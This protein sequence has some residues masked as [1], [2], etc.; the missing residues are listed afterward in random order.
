M[1]WPSLRRGSDRIV[2]HHPERP[3]ALGQLRRLRRDPDHGCLVAAAGPVRVLPVLG[4]SLLQQVGIGFPDQRR[5]RPRPGSRNLLREHQGSAFDVGFYGIVQKDLR[6][7]LQRGWS[8]GPLN[9][10]SAAT[11]RW[12][13]AGPRWTG[14]LSAGGRQTP[15]QVYPAD[16]VCAAG[17]QMCSDSIQFRAIGAVTQP[18]MEWINRPTFQQADEIQG[19]D[20]ARRRLKAAGVQAIWHSEGAS[21]LMRPRGR[22]ARGSRPVR[23]VFFVRI[24]HRTHG[25][26]RYAKGRH[27]HTGRPRQSQGG[28]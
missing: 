6:A 8:R 4:N 9:R 13:K 22:V 28:A 1:R 3:G 25:S 14:S 16:K 18:L 21:I 10:I 20:P 24:V 7:V 15:R 12:R 26:H 27:P 23:R 11:A 17:D 5:A 19:T 2:P